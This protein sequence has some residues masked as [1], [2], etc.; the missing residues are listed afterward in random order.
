MILTISTAGIQSEK[1]GIRENRSGPDLELS[2]EVTDAGT[3]TGKHTSYPKI[4]GCVLMS[5]T[6]QIR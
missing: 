2:F 4:L 6:E 5:S 1:R 3:Q